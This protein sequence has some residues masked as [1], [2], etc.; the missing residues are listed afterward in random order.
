M[1]VRHTSVSFRVAKPLIY[2]VA[3]RQPT[4][5]SGFLLLH[6]YAH[7]LSLDSEQSSAP[8]GLTHAGICSILAP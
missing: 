4:A 2:S 1:P 8:A 5:D 7:L 3:R 6:D